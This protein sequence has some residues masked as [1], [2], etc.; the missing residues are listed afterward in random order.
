M[1]VLLQVSANLFRGPVRNPERAL[2]RYQVEVRICIKPATT[3]RGAVHYLSTNSCSLTSGYGPFGLNGTALLRSY[4]DPLRSLI[5]FHAM[6][7]HHTLK[8]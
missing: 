5:R 3:A 4:R 8:N 6:A 7:V 1:L 2:T